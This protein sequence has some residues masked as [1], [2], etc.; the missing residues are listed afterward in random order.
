MSTPRRPAPRSRLAPI[1]ATGVGP[2]PCVTTGKATGR[3]GRQPPSEVDP[4]PEMIVFLWFAPSSYELL[5]APARRG[6]DLGR[7][8]PDADDAR[9]LL[10]AA[11]QLGPDSEAVRRRVRRLFTI[12]RFDTALLAPI[13]LDM[14][15]KPTF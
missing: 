12:F 7:R 6:G 2:C 15:A 8:R 4:A 10:R 9:H 14:T 13:V 11:Q 3:R 1:T 5:L